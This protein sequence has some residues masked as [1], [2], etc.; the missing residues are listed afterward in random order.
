MSEIKADQSRETAGKPTHGAGAAGASGPDAAAAPAAGVGFY[1]GWVVAVCAMLVLFVSNGMTIGG[2]NVFDESLL[3]EFGWSRSALKFRDM[4]TFALVG[5]MGPFAGALADKL[6]VRR[7][8]AVGA[9]LL[10]VS[11][12]LYGRIQSILHMYIIH[13]LFA[14][15]LVTLGLIVAIILVSHWFDQKRGTAIGIALVGTSL[16]GMFFPQVGTWL[17]KQ[18]GWRQAMAWEAVFPAALLLLIAVLVRNKP[19]DKGLPPVGTPSRIDSS[20]EDADLACQEL[21]GLTYSEALRT[22]TFW[23]LAFI[24]M[25]TFYSILGAQAHLFLYLRDME[26]SLQLAGTGVSALFGL[27]LVGK[28]LFGFLADRLNQKRVFLGNMSVML[29]GAILLATTR[30]ELFWVSVVL[31]GLGWGGLYTLLQLL[32][33]NCFGLRATGKIIGTITVVDALGGGLGIWLTGLLYDVTGSYQV[34]FTVFAVLIVVA[35]G[36]ATQVRSHVPENG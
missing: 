10:L 30:I 31:F 24:A 12:L 35:M 13:V 26:L 1:Y 3:N 16:G 11:F 17:I 9:G 36:L 4:L 22:F 28:F 20:G 15:V 27:A 7:L 8:M 6:G 5:I 34:P 14:V 33:V 32:T 19:A 23:A 29:V 25:T 18:V 21:A 2:I